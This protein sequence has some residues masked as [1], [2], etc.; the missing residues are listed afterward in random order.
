MDQRFPMRAGGMRGPQQA[1][2][3]RDARKNWGEARRREA[4]VSRILSRPRD[5]GGNH[6]SGTPVARRLVR[7]TREWTG[8][9]PAS[10]RV[11]PT[12]TL[13]VWP[14]S[15]WGLPQ[16]A[17]HPTAGEL[18]P[19]HFTLTTRR[20]E[21]LRGRFVSVALS[22][23]SPP[24]AV[25]QHPALWSSDFPRPPPV[26]QRRPRLPGRL[27]SR[28]PVQYITTSHLVIGEYA[29]SSRRG[30]PMELPEEQ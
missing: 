21:R 18:L 9:P 5:G 26:V 11:S 30:V 24:L 3:R 6:L 29:A 15:G 28:P 23:G 10:R 7:P 16:P 25:N 1:P 13:P 2:I 20:R 4:T 17:G 22:L 8:E 19:R 27:A 14:C 12:T